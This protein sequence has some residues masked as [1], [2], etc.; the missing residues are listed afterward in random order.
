MSGVRAAHPAAGGRGSPPVGRPARPGGRIS[1]RLCLRAACGA[2]LAGVVAPL[3]GACSPLAARLTTAAA[4]PVTLRWLPWTG[5]PAGGTRTAAGLLLEGLRPWIAA[6]RGVRVE[7][8]GPAAGT[9]AAMLAGHGPDVFHGNVLPALV[10]NNLVH[11]IAPY[12]RSDGVD[13]AVFP[14]SALAYAE[15]SAS[16]APEGGGLFSLPAFANPAGMAV[17]LGAIAA[18][19]LRKP[20]P[21]W[22]YAQWATLWSAAAARSVHG[23]RFGGNLLWTGYDNSGGNP[24]P[25]YLKGFGGEYVEPADPAR[26]AL[27][28]PGSIA[29]LEW[30]Y[31]LR[32]AGVMGG[33]NAADITTQRQLSGP[34]GTGGMGG[35][36]DLVYAA[37]NWGGL[38]WDILPMPVWPHGPATYGSSDFYAVGSATP[39]PEL[40]WSLLRFLC[41]E[42]TWQSFMMQVALTGPNQ[43][44]LWPQ[45]ERTVLQIASPLH[46]VHLDV[47]TEAVQTDL[48]YVGLSFRFADTQ[49]AA[50]IRR[51]TAR[52]QAG[53]V[54]VP[55]A[56][57]QA[58]A[59]VDALE[60]T[61]LKLQAQ[62]A[63]ALHRIEQAA[64]PSGS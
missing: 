1:R 7:V 20:A 9:M 3:L 32:H 52:A 47:F 11:N 21:G 28:A 8:S 30:C 33:D 38:H 57:G 62:A 25:F 4:S 26:C 55:V 60:A 49:A 5:F 53:Q 54:S 34:L 15:A 44:S 45:W 59:I 13:L 58:V 36:G 24:A 37:T 63:G 10:Q 35:A 46:K 17:N 2:A 19:G 18:L 56:A 64:S 61:G 51:A 40:A 39:Y 41:V 16:F 23:R 6:N 14:R 12:V 43:K 42:A 48:P 27:S 50:A 29:C 31:A 22:T